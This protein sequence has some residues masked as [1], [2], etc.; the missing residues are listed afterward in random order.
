MFGMRL[1]Q[2][3][4]MRGLESVLVSFFGQTWLFGVACLCSLLHTYDMP[5][6]LALLF[7]YCRYDHHFVSSFCSSSF[8]FLHFPSFLARKRS[9]SMSMLQCKYLYDPAD[10]YY[11]CIM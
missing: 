11:V 1:R 3:D 10:V 8:S 2:D 5:R 9:P 4:P 7:V 6:L